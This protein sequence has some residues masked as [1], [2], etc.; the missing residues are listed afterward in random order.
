MHLIIANQIAE[1]VLISDKSSFLIGG[2]AP[3]SVSPKDLSH[4]YIGDVNDYS[5]SIAYEK[6]IEKYSGSSNTEFILGYYTHLIADDLWLKGFYLPW[7]KNRMEN[8]KEIFNKYN[9]CNE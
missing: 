1:K 2:I 8:D 7:L 5:R 6:F 4:F 9:G 3:D